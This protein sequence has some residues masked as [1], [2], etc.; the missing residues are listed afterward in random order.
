MDLLF[1]LVMFVYIIDC[2]ILGAVLANIW[3]RHH[4]QA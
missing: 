1:F 4:G 3:R 2:A